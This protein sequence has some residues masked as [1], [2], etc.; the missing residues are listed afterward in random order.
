MGW[1]LERRPWLEEGPWPGPGR[2]RPAPTWLMP[3]ALRSLAATASCTRSR[4]RGTA[5][6]TVGLY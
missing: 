4:M 5:M 6:S 2:H 3:G 1:A